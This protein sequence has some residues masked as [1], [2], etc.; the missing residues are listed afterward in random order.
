[1]INATS[2]LRKRL[3]AHVGGHAELSRFTQRMPVWQQRLLASYDWHRYIGILK[4]IKCLQM[5]LFRPG[6][7]LRGIYA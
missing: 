2:F 7:T 4:G 5:Q 3:H 6:K 1:M